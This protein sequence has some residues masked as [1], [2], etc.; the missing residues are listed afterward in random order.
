MGGAGDGEK[1]RA[2]V[3][4][5]FRDR[6]QGDMLAGDAEPEAAL[7]EVEGEAEA[8]DE[9]DGGGPDEQGAGVSGDEEDGGFGHCLDR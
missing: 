2:N 3:G 7:G 6:G 1:V 5:V 4:E 9:D 8:K